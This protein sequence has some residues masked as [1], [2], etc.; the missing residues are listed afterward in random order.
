MSQ[1]DR[2]TPSLALWKDATLRLLFL[3]LILVKRR[4]K[5]Q[6]AA[7]YWAPHRKSGDPYSSY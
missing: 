1:P 4:R 7:T 2:P 6:P 5:V 3:G